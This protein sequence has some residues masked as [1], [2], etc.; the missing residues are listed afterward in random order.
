MLESLELRE[1][2]KRFGKTV[3]LDQLTLT[4][5]PGIVFATGPN[6]A[7]KT[8]MLRLAAGLLRPSSGSVFLGDT[9]IAAD[10][11]KARRYTSYLSD[12]VPLYGDLSIEE[13]LTY[14]GR[15]KGL[16][17]Q[18][19]RARLRH[20]MEHFDLLQHSGERTVSLSAGLR[21]R[22]GIADAMLTD[23]RLLLVD[24]PFAGVDDEHVKLIAAEFATAAKRGI[25]LLAT[26]RLDIAGTLP[27]SCVV[28]NAG[29]L[30]GVI[31]SVSPDAP[32]TERYAKTLSRSV[33]PEDAG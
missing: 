17:G 26:H 24:E 1:L 12:T 19:L 29:T 18:R 3:A 2:T 6:G 31:P 7:G 15:L 30:A 14:R 8:T 13:H 27:G 33:N 22:V 11:M 10:P 21:K 25:V 23:S 28:L 32:L 16:S 20:V 5:E 9:D 4:L